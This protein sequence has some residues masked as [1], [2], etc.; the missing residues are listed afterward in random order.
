MKEKGEGTMKQVMKYQYAV[1]DGRASLHEV[2]VCAD[3][4]RKY[5]DMILTGKWRLIDKRT[6]PHF[7]C[8]RGCHRTH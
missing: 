5:S 7:N 3:C 2:W 1:E 8:E 6:D 4:R